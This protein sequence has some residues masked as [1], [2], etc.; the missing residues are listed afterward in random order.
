MFTPELIGC[1]SEGY[2][3][4][5]REFSL[6]MRRRRPFRER[7]CLC[8][9]GNDK[10]VYHAQ[11]GAYLQKVDFT[12]LRHIANTQ[13]EIVVKSG[14][15]LESAYCALKY[16]CEAQTSSLSHFANYLVRSSEPE[17]PRLSLSKVSHILPEV[18]NVVA[19]CGGLLRAVESFWQGSFLL[20]SRR[21]SLCGHSHIGG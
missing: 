9:R 3:G 11:T 16:A 5:K 17:A 6:I 14:R 4:P 18:V 19:V 21:L 13:N 15:G 20:E 12:R 1:G 2:S 8:T 10:L 7:W